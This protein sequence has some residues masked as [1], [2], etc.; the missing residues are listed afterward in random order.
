MQNRSTF[1]RFSSVRSLAVV[2]ATALALLLNACGSGM[3]TEE[4]ESECG[5]IR[6]TQPACIDDNAYA[7]CV[8]CHEE[9]GRECTALESCPESFTCD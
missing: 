1:N 6:D 3:T 2:G 5:R 4:A 8:S 7:Q 9:C